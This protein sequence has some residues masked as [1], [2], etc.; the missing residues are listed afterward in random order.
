MLDP[1]KID[2][3]PASHIPGGARIDEHSNIEPVQNFC[4]SQL[5]RD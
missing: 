4:Q 2:G 5:L 3:I 1:E